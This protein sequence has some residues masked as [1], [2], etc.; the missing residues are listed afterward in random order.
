M[1]KILFTGGGGAG[2]EALFRMLQTKYLTH[3]ADADVDSIDP[4]IPASHRHALPW[5]T[6]CE[7]LSK[8]GELCRRLSIDLIVPGVDEE[9]Y[10]LA[11]Q[12]DAFG[13]TRLLLPSA[14]YIAIMLDKLSMVLSLKKKDIPV[15]RTYQLS[16]SWVDLDF[17]CI[18]K[19]RK[20]RGSRG[21]RT[22]QNSTEAALLRDTLGPCACDYIVQEKVV[23][24]EYTVQ[25]VA[26]AEGT[27]HAVVPVKVYI[28]RGVTLR[29]ETYYEPRVIAACIAIH[30]ALP[31]SGCY[32]IQLILTAEGKV[33][34]F[35]INPRVSTT[36]CLV[37]ASGVDPI[38]IF[39]S[40]ERFDYGKLQFFKS[41][42]R[43]QRHWWN[44]FISVAS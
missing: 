33:M 30:E 15:P 44:H 26:T 17:P 40:P 2:N 41:G 16:D 39:N 22:L 28:K 42:L 6:D 37:V 10:L 32:N 25:M 29:A 27:L 38:E 24:Q 1:L 36:L 19:P 4:G 11:S 18:S 3:F 7:F 14:N 43:L 21:V 12:S 8:T 35:E 34:P 20:G 23:G 5:A 13:A 9:L 31:T